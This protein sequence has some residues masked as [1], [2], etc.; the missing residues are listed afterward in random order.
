MSF[1]T[2]FFQGV[3]VFVAMYFG[4]LFTNWGH[5]VIG[6]VEDDQAE[7]GTFSM[8]VKIVSQWITMSMFSVSVLI[9]CCCPDRVF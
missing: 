8:W 1:A 7:N 5:A 3:M 4:M 9:V 6:D 2:M